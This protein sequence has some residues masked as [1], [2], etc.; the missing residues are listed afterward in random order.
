MKIIEQHY[1]YWHP[2]LPKPKHVPEGC[3][4]YAYEEWHKED[5]N[6]NTGWLDRTRRWP[7]PEHVYRAHNFCEAFRIKVPEGY[8][9]TDFRYPKLCETY[10]TE[11]GTDMCCGSNTF[12][13]RRPILRMVV[14]PVTYRTPTDEDAKLRPQVE[15]RN[16]DQQD[17]TPAILYGVLRPGPNQFLTDFGAWS[18]CRMKVTK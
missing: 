15:V 10:L 2:G 1:L 16:T 12:L 14:P 17:W 8:E 4:Y 7:V 18:Q 9:V 11:D 5:K 3:E 6:S 13:H